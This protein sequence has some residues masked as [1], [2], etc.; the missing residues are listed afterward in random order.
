M[1]IPKIGPYFQAQSFFNFLQFNVRMFK[2]FLST[3]LNLALTN[4][5]LLI[6]RIGAGVLMIPHGYAKFVNFTEYKTTFIDFLGLGTEISLALAVFAEL[7]CSALLLAGLF[8]RIALIP[9]FIT[10]TVIVFK[11][12][13]GDIFGEAETGSLFLILYTALLLTGPGK[14]SLDNQI[15]YK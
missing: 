10:A 13:N 5:A 2:S 15:S 4:W 7:I 1:I 3:K 9:L 12:H 11:A 8:T 14:F 6:L